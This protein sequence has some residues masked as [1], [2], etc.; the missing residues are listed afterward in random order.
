[1]KKLN[2]GRFVFDPFAY[3][4]AATAAASTQDTDSAEIATASALS[5]MN[6]EQCPKCGFG[7]GKAFLADNETVY[8][9]TSCRVTNPIP[10]E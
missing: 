5:N 10:S 9:C 1:M 3:K 2:S 8:Y 7:M 6:P 4:I